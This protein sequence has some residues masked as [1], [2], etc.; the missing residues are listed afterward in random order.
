MSGRSFQGPYLITVSSYLKM[1]QDAV[2]DQ[3][4]NADTHNRSTG[5]L[6]LTLCT[7]SDDALGYRHAIVPFPTSYQVI[8]RYLGKWT[9]LT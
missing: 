5:K 6:M 2:F 4:A 8:D 3:A 7:L 1:D 9:Y